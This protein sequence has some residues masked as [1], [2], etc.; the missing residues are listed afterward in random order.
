MYAEEEESKKNICKMKKKQRNKEK[1]RRKKK[2]FQNIFRK[3]RKK[4]REEEEELR[5]I[6]NPSQIWKYINKKRNKREWKENNIKKGEWRRYFM[7]LLEGE[8]QVGEQGQASK[9]QA[10]VVDVDDAEE[11]LEQNNDEIR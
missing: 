9:E 11:D 6:Q 4:K 5:N 10:Q 3:K 7:N 2:K 8:D 1:I